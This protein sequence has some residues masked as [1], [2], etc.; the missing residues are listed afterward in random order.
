MRT[1]IAA[2]T[3]KDGVQIDASVSQDFQSIMEEMNDKVRMDHP[4]DSF[5]RV[6]WEQQF[7]VMSNKDRR[8]IR[9]HPA[10]IKWCLHLKYLSSSAYRALRSSSLLVLP[11]ERTLRDY[12]HFVKSSV[13]FS[14]GLNSQ[15]LK[16]VDF[17]EERNKYVTLIWDEMKI[18]EGLVFDKYNCQLIGFVDCGDINHILDSLEHQCTSPDKE[19]H[20]NRN[21]AT[22]MLVFMVRGIFSALVFPY[23]QFPTNGVS[24]GELC[25]M[26]WEAVYN[27]EVSGFKVMAFTCDGAT[28]NRKFFRMQGSGAGTYK[29]KNHT[30][31]ILIEKYTFSLMFRTW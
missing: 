15:L 22:H 23:A 10:L 30:A 4:V 21:V 13:G 6:F 12:T 18:K 8:Q 26:V 9:W 2:L 11:S 5:R 19:P 3:S 1:D 16:E 28:C 29:I 24:S 17:S 27:L 31:M 20:S 7:E 25:P 14:K